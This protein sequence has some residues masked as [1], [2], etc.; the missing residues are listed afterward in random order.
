MAEEKTL[1]YQSEVNLLV[2]KAG[3]ALDEFL[4]LNQEQVDYIVAKCSDICLF[5]KT[6]L[7]ALLPFL[8]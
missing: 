7:Q 8:L 4:A 2:K 6:S 1:D 5:R 3:K